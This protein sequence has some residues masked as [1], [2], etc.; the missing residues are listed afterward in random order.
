M[1]NN[2]KRQFSTDKRVLEEISE[3]TA[4]KQ[5]EHIKKLNKQKKY[6]QGQ[7]TFKKRF[8]N[9]TCVQDLGN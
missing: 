6:K 4:F 9:V 5:G 3:H 7:E 1:G 8:R 2:G